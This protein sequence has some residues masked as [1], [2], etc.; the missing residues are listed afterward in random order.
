[1]TSKDLTIVITTYRS[2]EKI[3]NC[4]NS[5]DSDIKVIIVENS[6]NINFKNKIEKK[7]QNVDCI[8]TNDN[9]GYGKANNIGLK[10]V[11]TKYSLILNPDT[12]LQKETINNFF[13]FLKKDIDFALL[14]PSQNE[15]PIKLETHKCKSLNLFE[16]SSIKGFAMFLNMS[17]FTDI[18]FFDENF[19]L[20]LEEIDLCKRAKKIKE[21]VYIDENIKIFHHGGKSVSQSLSYKTELVRNWHWM[22]SLFYYNKKH[23][24]YFYALI[25][26]LPKF[27]SAL[28]K[29]FFYKF[30][31]NSKKSKIYTARLYGLLNSIIGKP[32][33]Y[34]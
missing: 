28:F 16:V 6:N 24:N 19:F 21:N 2:E 20:Y 29:S 12:I 26:V 33:S 17:K 25:L 22:W 13:I 30:I 11:L 7:F 3:E 34:R 14:G 10:K 15:K 32:S 23:F 18:G 9:F 31:F 27:F 8:L 5:I 4:L 1:M